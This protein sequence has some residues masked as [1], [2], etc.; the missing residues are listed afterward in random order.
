MIPALDNLVES[1]TKLPSIGKKSAWRLAL[2][3][4][5]ND[6]Q[7]AYELAQRITH[8]KERIRLCQLCYNYSEE[9]FCTVCESTSRDNGI[10][11]IV[12]KGLDVLTVEKSGR[13]RGKYHVLGGAL[14]PINGITPET[15]RIRELEERV[16]HG[17]VK[18]LILA[19]G[20]SSESETTSLYISRLLG[21]YPV[22]VTRLARGLPAGMDLEYVDQITLV[23]ALNERTEI[24]Y[25]KGDNQ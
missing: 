6:E 17:A 16:A 1:L 21:S 14:S 9:E 8:V 12:E 5:E 20:S 15:L 3:I 7:Y 25:N 4:L 24:S 2:H 19:L 13:Y 22:K 18:E 11:C 10:L 23:Q